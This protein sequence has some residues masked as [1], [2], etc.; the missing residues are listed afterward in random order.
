[1]DQP[2]S[3][4]NVISFLVATPLFGGLD[5]VERADV[6]RIM[7]VRRLNA[8]EKVFHEG[9]PGDAWYVI[10]EGRVRVVKNTPTGPMAIASLEPG[11][12][13]GEMAILDGSARSATIEATEPLTVF[14]FRRAQFDELLEEGSLAA[15][16]LVAAMARVLSERH[17]QLTQRLAAIG[18][19]NL[20]R[21]QVS[22]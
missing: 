5:P 13:F 15:Y 4:E 7:E 3:L 8:G 11:A 9:D 10:F 6:V 17:R 22:E 1:M 16:K 12:C 2:I 19:S 14:R 20:G 18:D 21:Y